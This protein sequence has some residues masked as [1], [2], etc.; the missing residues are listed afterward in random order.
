MEFGIF[1]AMYHPKHWR[2]GRRQSEHET[3]M[4]EVEYVKLAD[5]TGFK[6]S[7]SSEHHFLDEYSHLSDSETFMAYALAVTERIHIG[8][9]IINITPPVN[10]PARVAERV[11]ML[12]HLG[13]GR[14]EFGTGRGSSSQEV[15]GFGIPSMELTREMYDETLPQIVRMWAEDEYS[16]D[17][18]FFTMPPRNV[19]PKPYTNPHPPIW[20]AAGSPGTFEKAARLG[21]G[22]LCFTVGAPDQLAPL[23]DIYKKNIVNAEPVGG[24]V[25]DNIMVTSDFFCLEDGDRARRVVAENRGNYHTGLVYKFLDSFPKPEGFPVWPE[26]PPQPTAAQLEYASAKSLAC[27]G[28][29]DEVAK[30]VQRYIDIGADQLTFGSLATDVEWDDLVES[31]ETFGKYIVPRF[32]TDPVHSTTRQ[33]EAQCGASYGTRL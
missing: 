2:N 9:G 14:F 23:I 7:W 32:D 6:Y 24:Y 5:R 11:A 28:N 4:K 25:N 17:G 13:Q 27:I 21:L 8:S 3:L 26:L 10:H 22:V 33:R 30:T 1:H 15:F 19:L 29:P 31:Y 16:F 20:V 18:R 12:D